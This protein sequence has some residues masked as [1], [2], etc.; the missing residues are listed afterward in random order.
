MKVAVCGYGP[1]GRMHAQLLSQMEHVKLVGVADVQESLRKR[2]EEEL[3]VETWV[4]GEALI[5]AKIADV[6][7]VCAPTFLHAPLA[8]RALDLGMHVFSEKPMALNPDQCAAMLEAAQ[9]NDRLLTVGQVLRFWPEYVCLKQAVDSSRFGRLMTLSMLRIGNVSVGWQGW[10][11]DEE[12]GGSQIFDRHIHDTDLTLWLLGK[13]K[14]VSAHATLGE[15]GGFVHSFTEYRY[16]HV[17]VAAE[18]SADLPDGYPFTMAY[19]AVFEKAALEYNSRNSPTLTLYKED[20]T[21]E[22]PEL[23]NPLGNVQTGLNISSASGYYLEDV[24]FLDCVANGRK[25]EIVTPESARDT[26]AVVRLEMESARRGA[27][28]DVPANAE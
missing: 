3:H 19:L 15:R 28:V 8:I 20:G 13:P 9:R 10:F 21:H 1:M 7:F 18:G 11:L 2:A 26:V 12:L 22:T 23:P 24:Y 16:P 17:T 4:S 5:D 27:P 25:P 6:I 14:A